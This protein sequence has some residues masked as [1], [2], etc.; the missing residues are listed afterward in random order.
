MRVRYWVAF[1]ASILLAVVLLTAGVGKL[2]GQSAFLLTL[3]TWFV[4]ENIANWVANWLPWV[5]LVLGLCLLV[6]FFPQ[7]AAGITA[8]VVAAFAM[9]N[10]WMIANGLGHH[11]CHCLGIMD[12][13]MGEMSTVTSLY[14]DIGLIILAL[15]VYFSYPGRFLN[16]R[17]WFMR[18]REIVESPAEE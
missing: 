11:P 1:W 18:W 13:I 6:G 10:G 3:E 12:N 15:A 4:S 2:M 7:I 16:T 14:V 8:L 9:H 17:P 5:E